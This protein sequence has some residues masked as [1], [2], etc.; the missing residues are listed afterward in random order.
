MKISK[1]LLSV[2]V[3]SVL[4]VSCDNDDDVQEPKGDYENGLLISGEGGAVSGSI[5]YISNDF[6]IVEHSIYNQIN[7]GKELGSYLQSLT[8][9]DENAYICVDNQSSITVVNRYTFEENVII[10]DGLLT[11]RYMTIVNDKG[12]ATN[13]GSTAD[14]TDDFIAIIDLI[15]YE[16]T[17]TIAVGNGPERITERNGK[18][19][20]SHR[21][22]FTTNNIISV[23]D[24]ASEIVSEI[25]VGYKPDDLIFDNDNNLVVLCEGNGSWNAGG[26]TAA[27]ISK[28]N[29][30]NN[31]VE[32]EMIFN[33]GDAP[34]HLTKFEND[35]YYNIGSEIYKMSQTANT[36][37]ID[38]FLT[39][40][41]ALLYDGGI[42]I[43]DGILYVLN[44]NYT[45]LSKVD[46]Y[47]LDT[48]GKI[49]SLE[50]PLGASKIYFN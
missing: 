38:S 50:A 27:V 30:T 16:V 39:S 29:T 9:D 34:I 22:G 49:N 24:I 3:L 2:F 4:F 7:T 48:K 42:A 12:Y 23:I 44:P 37:P 46:L 31:V 18:L 45:G 33:I 40:E 13:W 25:E 36:L 43:N 32:S 41:S 14:A 11:P 8:F 35:L 6:T 15:T 26:A 21:G 17:G 1:L 47:D 5:S 10:T 28:I 20:V 19:Y